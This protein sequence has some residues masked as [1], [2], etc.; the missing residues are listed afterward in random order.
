V[1]FNTTSITPSSVTG[2]I[3]LRMSLDDATNVITTSF[4][5]DGGTTFQSPF[6]PMHAFNSGVTDYDI[7]LGAA[8]LE[9]GSVVTAT[10]TFPLDVLVVKNGASPESRRVSY[11]ATSPRGTGSLFGEPTVGGATFR[12]TVDAV[13]Q[14]FTLPATFWTRNGPVF[15]YRDRSGAYGPVKVAS[16]RQLSSGAFQNKI[17]IDGRRGAIDVV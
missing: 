15:K 1:Q 7:L 9:S 8:G 2:P 11:K 17:V 12:L 16:F 5:L 13:T 10:Q 6:P 14:C 3:V 4:S